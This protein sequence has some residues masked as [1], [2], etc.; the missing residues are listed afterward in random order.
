ML[1]Q[2]AEQRDLLNL[3]S[4]SGFGF[5]RVQ[6]FPMN[7][8]LAHTL[9]FSFPHGLSIH[10]VQVICVIM[11]Y[12]LEKKTN[13]SKEEKKRSWLAILPEMVFNCRPPITSV[14]TIQIHLLVRSA[15]ICYIE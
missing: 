11:T 14:H 15:I 3:I 9:L 2:P 10:P 1:T 6:S 4:A 12:Y 5:A 13:S 7:L 8:V